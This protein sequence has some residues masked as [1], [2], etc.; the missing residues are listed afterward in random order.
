M[1][2]VNLEIV[3]MTVRL[4]QIVVFGD[5]VLLYLVLF[6]PRLLD[7]CFHRKGGILLKVL[8]KKEDKIEQGRLGFR[9]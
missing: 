1:G 3:I 8:K 6:C 4:P 7:L 2:I 5:S 9:G